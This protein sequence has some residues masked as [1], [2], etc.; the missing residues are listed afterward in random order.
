MKQ[1]T[2]IKR[3]DSKQSFSLCTMESSPL[4]HRYLHCLFNFSWNR[5]KKVKIKLTCLEKI[6]HV[7]EFS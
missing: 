2:E 4:F 7:L 6:L 1:K 3:G 5:V